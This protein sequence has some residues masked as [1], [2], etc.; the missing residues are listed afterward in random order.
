MLLVIQLL[1]EGNSIRSTMRITGVDGN[2]IMKA[3]ALAGDRAEK[4]EARETLRRSEPR[5][6][7]VFVAIEEHSKLVLNVDIG[8]RD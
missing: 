8:K 2:T 4:A 3:L 1:L 5:G 7:Y 6:C